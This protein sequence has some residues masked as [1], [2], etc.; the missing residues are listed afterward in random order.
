LG[1]EVLVRIGSQLPVP[2][3]LM[4]PVLRK[5][6]AEQNRRDNWMRLRVS[7]ESLT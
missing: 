4:R 3:G 7:K 1:Y 5:N 6:D 2:L